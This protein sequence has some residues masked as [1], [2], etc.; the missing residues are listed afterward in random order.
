MRDMTMSTHHVH[1]LKEALRHAGTHFRC[2]IRL[3]VAVAGVGLLRTASPA[4]VVVLL[5][6]LPLPLTL[7]SLLPIVSAII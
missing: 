1:L 6:S 3:V 4:I 5:L 2:V 7:S